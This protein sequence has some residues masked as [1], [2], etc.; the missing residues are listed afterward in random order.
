[1]EASLARVKERLEKE[2]AAHLETRQRVSELEDR[3]QEL[4]HQINCE[5]GE[6]HRLEQLVTSGNIPDDAKVSNTIETFCNQLYV[7]VRQVAY[8]WQR[9]I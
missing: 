5:R 8:L 4:D 1:M 6:R 9:Q 3:T 2:T 7:D